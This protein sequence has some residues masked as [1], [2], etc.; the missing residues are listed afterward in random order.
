MKLRY[1]IF[2]IIILLFLNNKHTYT[3][4]NYCW[5]TPNTVTTDWRVNGSPNNWNWMLQGKNHP[6]YLTDDM[7]NYSFLMELPYFQPL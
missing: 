5:N 2:A 7:N 1:T 6:V 3:Q 4:T